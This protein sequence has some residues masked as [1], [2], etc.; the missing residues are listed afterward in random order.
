MMNKARPPE[1]AAGIAVDRWASLGGGSAPFA[2]WPEHEGQFR[3][4]L[5]G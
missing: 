3:P 1:A 5:N 4:M 2:C